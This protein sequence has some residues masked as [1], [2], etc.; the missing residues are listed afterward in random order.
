MLNAQNARNY[1]LRI[2]AIRRQS[3]AAEDEV[4]S[5]LRAQPSYEQNQDK[6]LLEAVR[7]RMEAADI[8]DQA[9]TLI[10]AFDWTYDEIAGENVRKE[11]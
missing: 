10:G 4:L 9:E 1:A 11:G 7:L 2:E 6:D 8:I 5:D 3:K